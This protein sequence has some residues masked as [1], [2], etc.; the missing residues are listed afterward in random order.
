MEITNHRHY[1]FDDICGTGK[2]FYYHEELL[3]SYSLRGNTT[4]K[5]LFLNRKEI[6]V[7]LQ[8]GYKEPGYFDD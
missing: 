8:F 5:G 7:S 6:I 1:C 3:I 4:G 2:G